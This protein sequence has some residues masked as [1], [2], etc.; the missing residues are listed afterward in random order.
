MSIAPLFL[1]IDQGGSSSRA[2]VYDRFGTLICKAQ[3]TVEVDHPRLGWVEQDAL[4][5][6]ESV[7]GVIGDVT[8]QLGSQLNQICAAGLATQRSNVV[9]WRKSD[10]AALSSAISWQDRRAY[11]WM[12]QYSAHSQMV[13]HKTGLRV[14]PHYGVSK[15]HWCLENIPEVM[16]ALE[17]EDLLCGPLASFL[18]YKLVND[19]KALV[20]PANASRTLLWNIDAGDWDNELLSLFDIP[21]RTLPRMA[22]TRDEFGY[23][24]VAGHKIPLS[25]VTGDQ[26]AALFAF[27]NPQSDTIYI[28]MGT[29]VFIQLPTNSDKIDIEGL[30]CSVIYKEG[31]HSEYVIEATINGAAN[32]L[33]EVEDVLGISGAYAESN[34]P[35]WAKKF[36]NPPLF[37]NGVAGLAAPYWIPDFI[38]RFI[39][40]GTPEEQVLAVAESFLFLIRVNLELMKQYID[41]ISKVVVTG[42]LSNS[43]AICQKLANL[44]STPVLRPAEAEATAQGLAFLVANRP[45]TWKQVESYKRFDCVSEPGLTA[46]FK[47]W[48]SAM[49]SEVKKYNSATGRRHS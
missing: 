5:L 12:D 25:L 36:T 42:G 31:N 47:L 24:P 38:S 18:V 15:I 21:G 22:A 49:E 44:I 30:L 40:Q 41:P 2:L 16:H 33:M 11:Q 39:G 14:S 1:A 37:L 13:R 35:R 46:R 45:A 32:A 20:D 10:G 43:D 26:S 9:C 34:L 7:K 8:R 17:S 4:M 27:G 6:V 28:N 23:L 19:P 48:E 29:G 3:R